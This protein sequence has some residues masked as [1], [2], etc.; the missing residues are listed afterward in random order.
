MKVGVHSSGQMTY[1]QFNDLLNIINE[2][3]DF[4]S[5]QFSDKAMEAQA[6][7]DEDGDEVNNEDEDDDDVLAREIYN[8][9][10]GTRDALPLVD[11][12]KWE[13]VQELLDTK[14]LSEDNL[15]DSI[16][17]AGI[18][19]EVALLSFEQVRTLEI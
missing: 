14:A 4:E 7:S 8:E 18:E 10:K 11:F 2:L 5:S 17:K 19:N 1:V 13:D 3:T 12:I 16:T 15:A 9:L 6:A